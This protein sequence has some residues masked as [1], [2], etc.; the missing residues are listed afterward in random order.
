MNLLSEGRGMFGI[1]ARSAIVLAAFCT[2][3]VCAGCQSETM[4]YGRPLHANTQ[5]PNPI[6]ILWR[7]P[8]DR[9]SFGVNS[10]SASDEV[11]LVAQSMYTTLAFGARDG[12]PLW[13]AVAGH[14]L[15]AGSRAVL[16]NEVELSY[17]DPKNGSPLWTNKLGL[18]WDLSDVDL[19]AGDHAIVVATRTQT[20]AYDLAS[21]RELWRYRQPDKEYPNETSTMLAMGPAMTVIVHRRAPQDAH[22]NDR[23]GPVVAISM[24]TGKELWRY[25]PPVP[26]FAEPWLSEDVLLLRTDRQ[27][28]A[29][30]A[31]T[32]QRIWSSDA[33]LPVRGGVAV[34]SVGGIAYS[35]SGRTLVGYDLVSG[36][37]RER[38]DLPEPVPALISLSSSVLAP[39]DGMLAIA[40]LRLDKHLH[41]GILYLYSPRERRIV[42]SSDLFNEA[43]Y[44]QVIAHNKRIF[45]M[46]ANRI[47][48]MELVESEK[49]RASE[50]SKE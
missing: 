7:S 17:V 8:Q 37:E 41:Q 5:Q 1:T 15:V 18:D 29:A 23:I 14:F 30:N 34:A 46:T 32:G 25:Q 40:C 6:R 10:P 48:A 50:D 38:V 9:Y 26:V 11:L 24:E 44:S 47:A 27:V 3:W 45:F 42:Y 21:G 39:V 33:P 43:I 20:A 2:A 19:A 22:K 16:L 12:R 49:G 4:D 13:R 31:K 35:V 28:I 36:A